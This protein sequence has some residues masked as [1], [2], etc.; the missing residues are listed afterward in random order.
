MLL[1]RLHLGES[2]E[3]MMHATGAPAGAYGT[4]QRTTISGV[5]FSK[6]MRLEHSDN[7]DLAMACTVERG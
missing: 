5:A 1:A 2:V 7:S 4:G 6:D 3:N